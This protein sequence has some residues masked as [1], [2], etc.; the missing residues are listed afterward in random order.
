MIFEDAQNLV[1]FL[2]LELKQ[3]KHKKPFHAE[4]QKTFPAETIQSQ[5]LIS[6]R[7]YLPVSFRNYLPASDQEFLW[8]GSSGLNPARARSWWCECQCCFLQA[9]LGSWLCFGRAEMSAACSAKQACPDEGLLALCYWLQSSQRNFTLGSWSRSNPNAIMALHRLST[10]RYVHQWL[11]CFVR[12]MCL[13]HIWS[14][15]LWQ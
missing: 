4:A 1:A 10:A 15:C 14:F 11:E 8:S 6:F 2:L 3:T 7:S 9:S 5:S 13:P 12:S